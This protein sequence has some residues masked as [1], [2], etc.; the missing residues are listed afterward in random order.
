MANLF[1]IP[2]TEKFYTFLSVKKRATSIPV[3][4]EMTR[5]A[6]Q[7][8]ILSYLIIMNYE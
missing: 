7:I 4:D 5:G 8:Y 2:Y 1:S 3:W 6:T